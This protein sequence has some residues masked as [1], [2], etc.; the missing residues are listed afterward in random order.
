[1]CERQIHHKI[2]DLTIIKR[3]IKVTSNEEDIETENEFSR[4]KVTVS[5]HIP[6]QSLIFVPN[7]EG[8]GVN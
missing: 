1:M 6:D 4:M 3:G 8:G 5:A 7:V 2:L